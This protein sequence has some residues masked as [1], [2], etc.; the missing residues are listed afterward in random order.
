V[1]RWFRYGL[2]CC[3]PFRLPVP[4]IPTGQAAVQPSI[5]EGKDLPGPIIYGETAIDHV[6]AKKDVNP[7]RAERLFD[8]GM[9]PENQIGSR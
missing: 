2:A 5:G 3:R 1:A 4:D 7:Q 8:D 9:V 6:A